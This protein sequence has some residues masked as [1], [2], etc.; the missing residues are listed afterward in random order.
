M[1]AVRPRARASAWQRAALC[2]FGRRLVVSLRV[3]EG[4]E[5]IGDRALRPGCH[6]QLRFRRLGSILGRRGFLAVLVPRSSQQEQRRSA[7]RRV[8]VP[9][10]RELLV[11]PARD[12]Q[13]DVRA[14]EEPLDRRARRDHGQR[15]VGARQRRARRH[16][17]HEPLAQRRRQRR[18]AAV[19]ER[20][21]PDGDRC[22]DRRRD[23]ELRHGRACRSARGSRRRRHDD[24]R[25]ADQQPGASLRR[26]DHHVAARGQWRLRL[27]AG[28]RPC[29]QRAHRRARV[30]VPHGAATRASSAPTP[31]PS[32]GS[33][34]TAACTTGASRRSIPSSASSTCPRAPRAT[35]STARIAWARTCSPTACSRS[36]HAAAS[37]CGTSR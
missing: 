36:M 33:A 27:V 11:Q 22:Q 1:A 18:A 28:R 3:L 8:D 10:R 32:R 4:P 21:L 24:P 25:V 5:P 13:H 35:T 16:A 14:R 12:R 17:R 20:G 2:W 19:P 23:P 29:L 37:D 30:G 26:P 15:A 9:D 34:T 6:R 7:R 31:G